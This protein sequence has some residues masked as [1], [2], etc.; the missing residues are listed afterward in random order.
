MTLMRM[1]IAT[2]SR[3][4]SG[5]SVNRN[6]IKYKNGSPRCQV[7][8]GCQEDRWLEQLDM[9][10]GTMVRWNDAQ[11]FL[12]RIECS[13]V[14]GEMISALT[15]K[16]NLSLPKPSFSKAKTSYWCD[17]KDL[18]LLIWR[19]GMKSMK[20]AC[21]LN[22]EYHML[23]LICINHSIAFHFIDSL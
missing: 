20:H 14:S 8:C 23:V 3:W 6:L 7:W 2:K 22:T 1:G 18:A 12:R 21:L 11:L 4:M 16:C 19:S 15:W 17:M 10:G 13:S 9:L 5:G